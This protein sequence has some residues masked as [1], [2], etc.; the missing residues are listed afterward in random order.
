TEPSTEENTES[1]TDEKTEPETSPE[2]SPAADSNNTDNTDNTGNTNDTATS[3]L[4]QT[5]QLNWPVPVLAA[6]G[7]LLLLVGRY[8][9]RSEEKREKHAS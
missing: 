6:G 8:L 4:P 3:T 5:G 1:S 7:I 2:T 9:K